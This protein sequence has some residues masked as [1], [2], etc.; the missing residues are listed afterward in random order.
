MEHDHGIEFLLE[1]DRRGR[2]AIAEAGYYVPPFCS[3]D[4]CPP[5]GPFATL[6]AARARA[7]RDAAAW[8]GL[9]RPAYAGIGSRRTPPE[10]LAVMETIGED[11]ARAGWTLRSGGAAGAD[12][13]FERGCDRA[14]GAKEIF[15]PWPRYNDHPSPLDT[16]T[17]AMLDL[18][19][20]LHPGWDRLTPAAR[21]LIARNGAQVLGDDLASPVALIVC[22]T[23]RA[24]PKGGTAQAL[25]IAEERGIPVV[26][27]GDAG[28]LAPGV[29]GLLDHIDIV[30]RQAAAL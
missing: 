27:L 16:V 26:N 7:E 12:A 17:D 2:F 10:V 22:W 21:L 28:R 3:E 29:D 19:A 11:L 24:L 1:G 4:C 20:R 18:A 30:S 6:P 13:A 23:A 14:G 15:L 5:H 9:P 25:R 8:V